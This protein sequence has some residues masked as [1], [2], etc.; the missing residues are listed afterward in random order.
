M[1]EFEIMWRNPADELTVNTITA[2][3]HT[4]IEAEADAVRYIRLFGGCTPEIISVKEHRSAAQTPK[5]S[6]LGSFFRLL[7]KLSGVA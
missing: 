1:R 5:P 3:A 4:S 6:R 2:M 7:R